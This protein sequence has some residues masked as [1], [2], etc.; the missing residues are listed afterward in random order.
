MHRRVIA[1]TALVA[2]LLACQA[3]SGGTSRDRRAHEAREHRTNSQPAFEDGDTPSA[4]PPSATTCGADK[5]SRWLNVLPTA[6][7]KAEI[8]K[9]VGE[10]PIRYYAKGDPIMMDF[11]AARL[12]AELGVDGRIKLF[13]CG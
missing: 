1:A 10:R 3:Q 4:T 6:D 8:A 11:R 13:R 7:V 12:N 9:S 2:T 5:L